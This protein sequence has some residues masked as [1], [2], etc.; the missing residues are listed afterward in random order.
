MMKSIL[1][2]SMTLVLLTVAIGLSM[3][4]MLGIMYLVFNVFTGGL[5]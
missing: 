4:V 2:D 5:C 3:G 1:M